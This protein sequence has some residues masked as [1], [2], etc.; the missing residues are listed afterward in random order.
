MGELGLGQQL[1]RVKAFLFLEEAELCFLGQAHQTNCF[2]VLC[3]GS[4]SHSQRGYFFLGVN[5]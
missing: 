5:V 1:P 2:W 4:L 3:R